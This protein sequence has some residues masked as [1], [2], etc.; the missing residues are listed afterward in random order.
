MF[1][2][3]KLLNFLSK[4]LDS[5]VRYLWLW[6][7]VEDSGGLE[8]NIPQE[9]QRGL[10][11]V[12]IHKGAQPLQI[13]SIAPYV[14]SEIWYYSNNWDVVGC[15]VQ[16]FDGWI[17]ALQERQHKEGIRPEIPVLMGDFFPWLIH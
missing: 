10:P 17:Q 5:T 8:K 14:V 16:I 13:R 9:W 7:K 1:F 11:Q 6:W 15:L 12:H 2:A 3:N 4:D